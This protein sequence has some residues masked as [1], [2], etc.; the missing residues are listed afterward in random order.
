[1]PVCERDKKQLT[2]EKIKEAINNSKAKE[3]AAKLI[4]IIDAHFN[5]V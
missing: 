5:V 1:M 2:I 4:E 3:T